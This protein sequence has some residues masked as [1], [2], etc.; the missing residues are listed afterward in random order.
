MVIGGIIENEAE[1]ITTNFRKL[2]AIMNGEDL[3]AE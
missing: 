1:E 2:K 3:P